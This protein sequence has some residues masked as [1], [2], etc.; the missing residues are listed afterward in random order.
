MVCANG[1]KINANSTQNRDLW[2]ALK[3]GGNNFGI[4]TNLRVRTFQN[5]KLWAGYLYHPMSVGPHLM[6]VFYNFGEQVNRDPY[7]NALVAMG[8]DAK[9]RVTGIASIIQYT[10]AEKNPEV[11][12]GFLDAKR[13]WSTIKFKTH[14]DA[15]K[16]VNAHS[17][18]GR[19]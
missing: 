18:A 7:G 2:I 9:L 11:L 17:P 8:Y 4:V 12:K 3:G 19:R 13:F 6:Q 14:G 10:K 5:S 15:T 1:E 16:E